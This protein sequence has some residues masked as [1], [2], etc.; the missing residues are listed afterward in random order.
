MSKCYCLFN[1]RHWDDSSQVIAVPA[2]NI[3]EQKLK[4]DETFICVQAKAQTNRCV[5]CCCD[6]VL[7]EGGS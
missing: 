2:T 7:L 6:V 5:A 3:L 1:F 4:T